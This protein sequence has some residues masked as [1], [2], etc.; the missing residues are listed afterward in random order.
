MIRLTLILVWWFALAFGARAAVEITEV[1]SPGGIKAWLVEEHSIPFAAL[2]IRFQG[3]A[4][5]DA[6][7]KRGA[8]NLMMALVEEGAGDMDAREFAAAREALAADFSFG[9]FNDSISVSA[10]FLT[11]NRDDSMALLRAALMVP[12]FDDAS[13]ERV[14]RQV[15]SGIR[16]D[17]QDPNSIASAAFDLTAFG[18]HPYGSDL[19]GTL[20]SV[21]ALTRA[22][23]LEAQARTMTRDRL[24][25]GAVGDITPE[26]LG[27]LLDHLLGELP[28]EGAPFPERAEFLLDGGLTVVPFDTPQS[29]AVFGHAG[30]KRDDPDFFAA[31]VM[32]QILGGGG[33]SSRLTT[34]VREKRGLTYGINTY[35]VPMDYTELYMGRVA[36][37]NERMAETIKVIRS[38]REKMADL[39]V[40]EKE[41]RDA[42]TYLTGAYPLRFD[43]NGPIAD[44]LVGM[45]IQGLGIDYIKTRNEKVEAVTADDIARVAA[46]LLDPD[47]LHFVI[48]GQPV[49]VDASN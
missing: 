35:L 22:D 20:E 49:D 42:I 5:L 15:I 28:E 46:R 48:V 3:G 16:S 24:F 9:T 47:A 14:R 27:V 31:Y 26:E 45:Q 7:G 8:T 34:E 33:F 1:T 12:N 4:S 17:A 41:L 39:G 37:A 10:R 13:V 29:V 2:E 6:P 25:V 38:E 18:D 19:S 32:N 44:I 21:T 36:S 23:I 30:I 43:G 40:G 11:E